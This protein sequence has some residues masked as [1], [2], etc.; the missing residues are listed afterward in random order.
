[1]DEIE[2]R[3]NKAGKLLQEAKKEFEMGL[4]ERCC[5]TSYYAMFHAAKALI[6]GLGK[7]SKTH[8][9]TIYLVWENREK[10]K[11]SEDDCL[12]LSRAFD[13]REESDYGIFKEISRD[14]AYKVLRDAEDFI[15]KAKNIVAKLKRE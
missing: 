4:Y 15:Y 13:L 9:G 6:L 1:M 12:K 10:L 8:R 2:L 5:S 7:D 11:L 14:L 3:I